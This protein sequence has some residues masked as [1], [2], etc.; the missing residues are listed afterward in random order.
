MH[1]LAPPGAAATTQPTTPPAVA[2]AE[3]AEAR[4]PQ[5]GVGSGRLHASRPIPYLLRVRA[6]RGGGGW[7]MSYRWWR[8]G[9]DALLSLFCQGEYSVVFFSALRSPPPPP[10]A[11]RSH[12]K[13]PPRAVSSTRF[14]NRFFLSLSV[15]SAARIRARQ[16]LSTPP[17]PT[18]SPHTHTSKKVS[19]QSV[20]F[21]R[22]SV[23]LS[24]REGGKRERA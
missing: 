3:A 17:T 22:D 7:K 19:Q 15:G 21:R 23:I 13:I 14:A 1:P 11:P 18:L 8:A 24:P 5:T 6:R 20:P 9:Q 2:E 12:P 4:A 16:V 10:R